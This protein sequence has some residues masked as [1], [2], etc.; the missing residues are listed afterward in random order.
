MLQMQQH[1][2]NQQTHAHPPGQRS[3]SY[4]QQGYQQGYPP[5][6]YHHPHQY[7]G[8]VRGAH[9]LNVNGRASSDSPKPAARWVYT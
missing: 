8:Q 6:P 3:M 1:Y 2:Q 9:E 7:A 4:Q 5:P